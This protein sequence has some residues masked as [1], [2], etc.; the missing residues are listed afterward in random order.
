MRHRYHPS[1]TRSIRR[2][3]PPV[4]R[5]TY[6]PSRDSLSLPS[7]YRHGKRLE[8]RNGRY[9]VTLRQA[10]YIRL[11]AISS[12]RNVTDSI[13]SLVSITTHRR[14]TAWSFGPSFPSSKSLACWLRFLLAHFFLDSPRYI[15]VRPGSMASGHS[16]TAITM[17]GIRLGQRG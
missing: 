3:V 9:G 14:N 11:K 12:C 13:S 5:S 7:H 8:S 2:N 6:R 16:V 1:T 17:S 10:I 15:G 4:S